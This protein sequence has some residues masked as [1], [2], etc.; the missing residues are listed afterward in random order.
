MQSL[1][2]AQRSLTFLSLR[3]HFLPARLLAWLCAANTCFNKPCNI[4]ANTVQ[5]ACSD[6]L[7]SFTG[8]ACKCTV[9]LA[10]SDRLSGCTDPA[11]A[12]NP[13]GQVAFA[14]DRSC[15][16]SPFAP[17]YRCGCVTG[18]VWNR[19]AVKCVGESG[20]VVV[21]VVL[22]VHEVVPLVSARFRLR[23]IDTAA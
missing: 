20:V 4:I 13:C 21:V 11:C 18:Y 19:D 22:A 17:G 23:C 7:G 5:D 2:Q 15:Q 16:P 10:W 9:G 1:P 12:A 3:C 8:F 14:V 6:A